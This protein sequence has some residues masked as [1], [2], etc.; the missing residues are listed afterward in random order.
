MGGDFSGKNP[1]IRFSGIGH[2][3]ESER[4]V[5]RQISG[6][7]Q[8]GEI[9]AVLGPN[10]RGKTTLIKILLGILVPREGRVRLFGR[11]G[12]VPQ[13]FTP[14]L[15]YTVFDIVLMGRAL[16]VGVF[17]T[18]DKGDRKI[19]S[20]SL[21][22]IGLAGM[23]RR[24]FTDLSGGERQMVLFA[25]ALASEGE[26]LILDE[27]VASMDLLNQKNI[28]RII[29]RL[30]VERNLTILFTTHQPQHAL[31]VADSAMLLMKGEPIIGPVR[32]V[33]NEDTLTR[34]Y[35][36]KLRRIEFDHEGARQLNFIPVFD[37]PSSRSH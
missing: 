28:L 22:L 23:A 37:I 27:P 17:R 31:A 2:Y 25:R 20:E 19:A 12:F 15:P 30:A 9:F 32:Q 16:H 5:L 3:Y 18:P 8:R 36:V 4:W 35:G 26:I 11:T 1:A 34:L 6:T 29:A 21:E 33:M 14:S 10:A 13:L 24:R 7:V